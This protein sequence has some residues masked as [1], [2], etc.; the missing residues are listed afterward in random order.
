MCT[1]ISKD[2]HP[3]NEPLA[4]E[5]DIVCYKFLYKNLNGSGTSPLQNHCVWEKEKIKEG[6]LTPSLHFRHGS[7][8]VHQVDHGFHALTRK[9]MTFRFKT[10]VYETLTFNTD[11]TTSG[12]ETPT[13]KEY[14]AKV[15]AKMVIPKGSKYYIGSH[16]DIVA[17]KM[18]LVE[19]ID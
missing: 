3:N 8:E 14:S 2:R 12:D 19:F 17:N 4:A 9:N 5:E 16:N 13:I 15:N 18:K 11:P 7:K 6:D 1:I 10:V